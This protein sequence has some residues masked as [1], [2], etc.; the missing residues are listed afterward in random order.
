MVTDLHRVGSIADG[1][2]QTS[3]GN[4]STYSNLLFRAVTAATVANQLAAVDPQS[5]QSTLD[6][7][8]LDSFMTSM[9]LMPQLRPTPGNVLTHRTS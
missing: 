9:R 4:G 5:R 8:N 7:S 1:A 3:G 2:F 6:A